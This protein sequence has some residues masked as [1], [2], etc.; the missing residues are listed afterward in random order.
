MAM[1]IKIKPLISFYNLQISKAAH[2][3]CCT[4]CNISVSNRYVPVGSYSVMKKTAD[5]MLSSDLKNPNT[6]PNIALMENQQGK[7]NST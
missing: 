4:A 6:K 3:P 5:L 2:K 1:G 7:F